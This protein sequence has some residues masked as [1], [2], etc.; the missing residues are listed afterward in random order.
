MGGGYRR[1]E[2]SKPNPRHEPPPMPRS[3]ILSPKP[4]PLL[5]LIC[6]SIAHRYRANWVSVPLA[7]AACDESISAQRLS[8]LGS[9]ALERFESHVGTLTRIGRPAHDGAENHRRQE[10]ALLSELLGVTTAILGQVSLR[11]DSVRQL[12]VGAWQRLK[13]DFPSLSQ[14]RFCQTIGLSTRTLRNWLHRLPSTDSA[15]VD[16]VA[17]PKT[18]PPRRHRNRRRPQFGFDVT[19]PETQ[20]AADTTDVVA[21]STPLKLVAAQDVGGRDQNLFE[22]II[23]D[24]RESAEHVTQVLT[25]AIDGREGMQVVTDQ[26]TPYVAEHTRTILDEL[27]ADHAIQREGDPLGK[28][29]VERAFG[30][31]KQIAQPLLNVT[32]TIAA[33]VPALHDGALA[34]SV[35]TILL[36]ALLRAY[37]AGSR[38][39]HRA[40]DARHGLDAQTLSQVAEE[41]RKN[42]HVEDTSKRQLLTHI[43]SAYQFSEPLR[44][45]IRTFRR[46]DLA[47]LREA[48][49][50]FGTQAHRDDI[51]NRQSYFAAIVRRCHDAH[52]RE[53]AKD[54]KNNAL[55]DQLR[56]LALKKQHQHER[57]QQDPTTWLTDAL[58][59]VAAQW[60]PDRRTLLFDGAGPG[61]GWLTDAF[62]RLVN[63]RG[64]QAAKDILHGV[65]TQFRQRYLPRI[66]PDGVAAVLA[67]MQKHIA[68]Q[69]PCEDKERDCLPNV[70]AAILPTSGPLGRPRPPLHLRT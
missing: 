51:R 12:I 60:L 43:H 65:I 25:E 48:E 14:E 23:V 30:T 67:L 3:H 34:K 10:C 40:D 49:H 57:W 7:D 24:D 63:L 35:V 42:A 70:R 55:Q 18:T 41:S 47:A 9:R 56:T 26:G 64:E 31:V 39:A 13:Q 66:G 69:M 4:S 36:T 21:F 8:R 27:G 61:P 62:A 53:L 5:A 11:R 54:I 17:K 19:M 6:L 15:P 50:R 46:F 33:K 59:T 29:T 22:A 52:R 45:F 37:Q 32:N 16:D 20:L 28:A 38:A 44:A 68:V 1:V 58:E 2:V